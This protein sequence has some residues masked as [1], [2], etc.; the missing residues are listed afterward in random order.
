[1]KIPHPKSHENIINVDTSF[2]TLIALQHQS[3]G[4]AAIGFF[5]KFSYT[6]DVIGTVNTDI[7]TVEITVSPNKPQYERSA[8]TQ[9]STLQIIQPD[10]L[11]D[12][13]LKCTPKI[14]DSILVYN[15]TAFLTIKAPVQSTISSAVIKNIKLAADKEEALALIPTQQIISSAPVGSTALAKGTVP[16]MSLAL[17]VGSSS[18]I[19]TD[20]QLVDYGGA[21]LQVTSLDLILNN[22]FLNRSFAA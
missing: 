22:S 1:M 8:W 18:G 9:P 2:A 21:D 10:Q 16:I 15:K 17:N 4:G 3:K 6:L 13:L 7:V 20:P 5:Y 12:N 14:K 11:V 19:V